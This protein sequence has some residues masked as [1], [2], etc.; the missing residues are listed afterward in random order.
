MVEAS[1]ISTNSRLS[2]TQ[3]D[4]YLQTLFRPVK[5][6]VIGDGAVG[7]TSLIKR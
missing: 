2:K 4:Q 1:N 3:D 5:V 7:K 6:V